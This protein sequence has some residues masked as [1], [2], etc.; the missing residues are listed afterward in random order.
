MIVGTSSM[1][2]SVIAVPWVSSFYAPAGCLSKK[3]VH[4]Q[5]TCCKSAKDGETADRAVG[6]D[7]A[8]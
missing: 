1:W 3:S 2:E 6:A 8:A 5:S 7:T 4:V